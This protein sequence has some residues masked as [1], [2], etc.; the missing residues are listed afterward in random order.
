L[1]RTGH[2]RG[3]ETDRGDEVTADAV[4]ANSDTVRTHRDLIGGKPARRFN[5]R[6]RYEP[7]CS[8]V[9][10]YVGLDR[11]YEHLAHHNF[12]FSQNPDDEFDSIYRKGE[13]SSDPTCYLAAPARTEPEVAPPQGEALYVLVHAPYLRPHHDWKTLLPAYRRTILDKLATTG[14]L[15]DLEQ[16]I[17]FERWLTP[18]DIQDQFGVL[19][20]AIYGL[21]SHG[22]FLGAF[23]PS[24]RSPDVK[25]LYFA[26]GSAHPGPGMSLAL[27]SGW[28]AADA[29]DRDGIAP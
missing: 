29:L 25:G 12:V 4:V 23:K 18:Q 15:R 26:G 28:I 7:A 10:L 2:V 11:C 22:K 19:N 6:R 9:V 21:A 20:G 16:R 8:G 27:M 24:N 13:P 5:R 17:R 3:L 1:D 14:G